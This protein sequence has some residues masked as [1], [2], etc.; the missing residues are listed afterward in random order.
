MIGFI[1]R[2]GLRNMQDFLKLF[3][4]SK[5]ATSLEGIEAVTLFYD[6]TTTHMSISSFPQDSIMLRALI[7]R[8]YESFLYAC[9]SSSST[10][11]ENQ[12][13]HLIRTFKAKIQSYPNMSSSES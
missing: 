2:A 12:F 9:S 7:L 5:D 10:G 4:I 6:G 1:F 8:S 11:K 3:I 13:N